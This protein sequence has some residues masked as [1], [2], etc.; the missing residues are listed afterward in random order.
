MTKFQ[1]G[2]PQSLFN[3]FNLEKKL[4]PEWNSNFRD[5]ETE[6]AKILAFFK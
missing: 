2:K 1:F 5:A 6:L 4:A 3:S